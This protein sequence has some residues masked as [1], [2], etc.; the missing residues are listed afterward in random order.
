M[1]PKN[2]NDAALLN[3]GAKYC[4]ACL[5]A[6]CLNELSLTQLSIQRLKVNLRGLFRSWS[7][8]FGSV[9]LIAEVGTSSWIWRNSRIITTTIWVFKW[10]DFKSFKVGD[11]DLWKAGLM[12]LKLGRGAPTCC[13]NLWVVF[14]WSRSNST[15]PKVRRRVMLIREFISDQVFLQ[16]LSMKGVMRFGRKDKLR[17]RFIG[18]LMIL[19]WIGEISY[20]LSLPHLFRVLTLCFIFLC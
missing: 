6:S 2:D 7:T 18:P 20:A 10:I 8:C 12:L 19:R 11:V 1:F 5:I 16:V 13:I 17:P 4:D 9:L 15:L 3:D 14:M